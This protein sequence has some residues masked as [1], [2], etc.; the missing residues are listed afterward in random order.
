MQADFGGGRH[1]LRRGGGHDG[2]GIAAFGLALG[3]EV[4]QRQHAGLGD[5]GVAQQV[6]AAVEGGAGGAAF[7]VTGLDEMAQRGGGVVRYVGVV[8]GVPEQVEP[9]V[10]LVARPHALGDEVAQQGVGG[11]VG[12]ERGAVI[13]GVEIGA[14]DGEVVFEEVDQE[15]DL[16]RAAEE[17]GVLRQDV[18]EVDQGVGRAFLD[19][20]GL[21]EVQQG[22]DLGV[23]DVG[24]QG[25]STLTT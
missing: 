18:F 12:A 8:F 23:G 10:G 14:G 2:D 21:D 6:L 19:E 20:A 24:V 1:A 25:C 22:V 5:V 3:G 4:A 13:G 11:G 15:F 7:G 9:G 17:A 16:G